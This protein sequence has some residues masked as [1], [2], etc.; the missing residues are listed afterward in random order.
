MIHAAHSS[1]PDLKG[2]IAELESGLPGEARLVLFFAS[3]AYPPAAIAS[4]MRQAFPGATT[5]GC[6]TAGEL[7]S[8]RVLQKSVVAMSLGPEEVGA[9]HVEVVRGVRAAAQAGVKAAL[10]RF[11]S[12]VGGPL[13]GLARDRWAGLVLTDGLSVAEE[14]IMETLS[15][16]TSL[17]FVGGSAGD[18]LAF[19][20]TH[21]F[22]NGEAATDASVLAL[23][24]SKRPFEVVKTQSF[25]ALPGRLTATRVDEATRTVYEFDGR[26]AAKAYAEALGTT[27]P[28]LPSHFMSHPLGLMVS[29]TEPFVRSPQQVKGDA[30]VFYCA[31]RPGMQLAVLEGG[32]IVR[33]TAHALAGRLGGETRAR[34]IV[35]FHCILRTLQLAQEERSEAYGRLFAQ[36]PMIGFSTYGEA[37]VGH[38]NQTSTLLVFG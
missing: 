18:D 36:V 23:F 31:M 32:D 21:V 10:G 30:V 37:Y 27:V 25:Q 13:A 38:I 28:D 5:I 22:A 2:A 6:T 19:S 12:R 11:E 16:A 35:N 14:R 4:A 15:D 7:V 34:G 33:D 9:L 8:G 24:E 26:P 1:N 3:P 20:A 29:A 17:A